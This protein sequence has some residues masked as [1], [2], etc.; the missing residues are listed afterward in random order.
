MILTT[1]IWREKLKKKIQ[2]SIF[3]EKFVKTQKFC[4]V[5]LLIT[6]ISREKIEEIQFS[7]FEEKIRQNTTVQYC[8]LPFYNFDFTRKMFKIENSTKLKTG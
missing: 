2:V 7:I 1:F 3:E 4:I 5:W 6:L 8:C